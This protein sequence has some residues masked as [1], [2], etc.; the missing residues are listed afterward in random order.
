MRALGAVLT[1]VCIGVALAGVHPTQAQEA[2]SANLPDQL[3]TGEMIQIQK[4]KKEEGQIDIAK[5]GNSA[6]AKR[7]TCTRADAGCRRSANTYGTAGREKG[8]A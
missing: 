2:A 1:V 5:S 6:G 3:Q 4:P 8:R 7:R